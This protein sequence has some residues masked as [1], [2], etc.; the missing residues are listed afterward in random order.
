MPATTTMPTVTLHERVEAIFKKA[1]LN[2]IQAGALA[3]VIVAAERDAC[4]SH[5]IYRIEGALCTIRAEKVV[6]DAVP[7]LVQ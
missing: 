5:G 3:R 4:K 1:G 7:E 6:P 2:D